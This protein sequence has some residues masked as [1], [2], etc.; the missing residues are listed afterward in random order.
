VRV[1]LDSNVLISAF[2]AKGI[3]ADLFRDVLA[4]HELL[5]SEY[6]LGEVSEKL[7]SKLHM[8]ESTV[9][10]IR[11]FLSRFVVRP[12]DEPEVEVV[13]RDPDDVPVV[14]FAQAIAAEVLITGDRDI[15]DVAPVLPMRV[16]SP[17]QFYSR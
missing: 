10:S 11:D 6:I 13:I 16:L 15:L 17:R 12:V 14:S 5:I 9:R 3:C 8:P 1:V 2:A 4:S 7:L